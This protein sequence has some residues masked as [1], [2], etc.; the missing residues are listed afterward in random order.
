MN[1]NQEVKFLAKNLSAK[2]NNKDR[3]KLIN[4][5]C[6]PINEKGIEEFFNDKNLEI[7]ATSNKEEA[8]ENANYIVLAVPTNFDDSKNSFD[9]SILDNV[10]SSIFIMSGPIFFIDYFTRDTMQ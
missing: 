9:T 10:I 8:F 7:Y 4:Q 6:S 2:M 1:T 5:K 3:I